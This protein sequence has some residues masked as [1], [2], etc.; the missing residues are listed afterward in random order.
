MERDEELIFTPIFEAHG[1]LGYSCETV[2]GTKKILRTHTYIH[3]YTRS[4][5]TEREREREAG[6]G[7]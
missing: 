5:G 3:K 4:F 7:L 6:R 1:E 2:E